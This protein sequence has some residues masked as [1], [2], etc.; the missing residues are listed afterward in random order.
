MS[1]NVK[2]RPSANT[3]SRGGRSEA[4]AFLTRE[5]SLL[6]EAGSLCTV[7]FEKTTLSSRLA[8]EESPSSDVSCLWALLCILSLAREGPTPAA[9]CCFS[10]WRRSLSSLCTRTG[11]LSFFSSSSTAAGIVGGWSKPSLR[12]F[13]TA[14]GMVSSH[15][16]VHWLTYKTK[17][18]MKG[19]FTFSQTWRK[20]TSYW[21]TRLV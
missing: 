19:F 1:A 11:S 9:C 3:W 5:G 12:K 7:S 6:A 17:Q 21:K 18:E 4:F 13:S 10:F 2:Y 20:I 16:L 8:D 15:S 14:K